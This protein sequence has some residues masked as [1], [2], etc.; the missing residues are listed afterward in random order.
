M[1]GAEKFRSWMRHPGYNGGGGRRGGGHTT[2]ITQNYS[3]EEAARRALVMDEARLIYD[4][5]KNRVGAYPGAR[6][7]QP[8]QETLAAENYLRALVP[9]Q[10]QNVA[11][12][13]NAVNFGLAD[14]LD[15]NRNPYMQ[16]AIQAGIRPITQS[17]LDPGGVMGQIRQGAIEAGGVGGSRQGVAEGIAAGRYAQA[18]GDTAAKMANEQYGMGLNTFEKTMMFAPSAMQ[19]GVI[20]A[21]TLA[22]VGANIEGRLADQEAWEEQRKLWEINSPWMPLQNYANI[23]YGGGSAGSTTR[24]TVPGRTTGQQLLGGLTGAAAGAGLAGAMYGSFTAAGPVGWAL[25]GLGALAG[26]L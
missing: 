6:P 18:I 12:L 15:V 23:V 16:G 2:S 10:V 11:S 22:N 14:V 21:Q 4:A 26:F 20:P 17:Y 24:G 13:N 1:F 9:G 8:T 7:I 5:N 3:P 19:A 25:A